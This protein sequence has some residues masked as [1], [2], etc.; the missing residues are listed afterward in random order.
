MLASPTTDCCEAITTDTLCTL[1]ASATKVLPRIRRGL[2]SV[3]VFGFVQTACAQVLGFSFDDGLDPRSQ[4]M[5][6]AWTQ[7]LLDGLKAAKVQAMFFPAGRIVD[8]PQGL[9]QVDAWSRAGHDVG[10]HT[11]SHRSFG[12]LRVSVEAFTEDLMRADELL[13]RTPRWQRRL[14]FPYLKEG[15]S[16]EKRD[17]LRAWMEA[18]GYR[19]AAVSIDTSDWYYDERYAA[20]GPR[21]AESVERF[22]RLYLHHLEQRA[23]FYDELARQVLGRSPAHVMLLHTNR[24]NAEFIGDVVRMFRSKGWTIVPPAV[25]YRDPLYRTPTRSLPAGESIVWALARQAGVAGLRYPA[26]DGTYEQ[27]LLD[28]ADE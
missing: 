10:N 12:S 18:H 22:R 15:E 2:L 17:A 8:S 3:A 14:R 27:R 11:Y 25:A 21:S 5:A 19:P 28:V 6:M 9:P 4:P 1:A 13:S 23:R 7:A 26:E 16:A 24:L 20:R